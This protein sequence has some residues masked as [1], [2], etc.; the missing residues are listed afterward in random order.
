MGLIR[1]N[2]GGG[3]NFK[4]GTFTLPIVSD[5]TITVP[6]PF[7]PKKV[8]IYYKSTATTNTYCVAMFDGDLNFSHGC[9]VFQGTTTSLDRLTLGIATNG[10]TVAFTATDAISWKANDA[11]YIAVG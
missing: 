2:T 10:F 7:T 4:E 6:L 9:D 8:A 5:G 11:Y 3:G 1:A